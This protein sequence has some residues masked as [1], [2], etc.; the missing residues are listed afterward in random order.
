MLYIV[1]F[2]AAV[3]PILL[4]LLIVYKIDKY[5]P[6]PIGLYMKNFFWGA[7]GAIF[8]A[9]IGSGTVSFL[10]TPFINP[11]ALDSLQTFIIAPFVE[12]FTK[13]L[14]LFG[15]VLNRKFDN[16]T[17]GLVYGASI[18]LGFG[19]TENFLYFIS[20][21]N[22]PETWIYVVIIRTLFTA[23]MHAVSTGTFGAFLGYAKFAG[24]TRKFSFP[25]I[26]YF[27][28][29]AIHS[30]WNITVS[31]EETT[32]IGFL[33]LFVSI[34]I[35]IAIFL[36][37]VRSESVLIKNELYEEYVNGLIPFEHLAILSSTLRNQIG[38]VEERIR[39][40]YI[41]AATNLAFRKAQER[42]STGYNKLFYHSEVFHNR[43]K[44]AELLNK[45][46]FTDE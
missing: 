24:L 45:P 23:V 26:G 15:T 5:D 39:K 34:L 14:F 28:A 46:L 7:L 16:T 6:E 42:N 21:A 43:N 30:A 37:S 12:E 27:L 19:M 35:F 18:G 11:Y 44:L 4:Y 40:E 9:L 20:Y 8:L 31:F 13:G 41:R 33:F 2:F 32:L 10:L 1:S 25:I 3:I 17:D 38:W 36:Q 22:L 29:V